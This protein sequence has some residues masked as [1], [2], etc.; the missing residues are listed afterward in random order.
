MGKQMRG[1]VYGCHSDG[2]VTSDIG[3]LERLTTTLAFYQVLLFAAAGTVLTSVPV[4][5]RLAVLF[6]SEVFS[7]QDTCSLRNSLWSQMVFREGFCCLSLWF[8]SSPGLV[9][10]LGTEWHPCEI[11]WHGTL[12][13]GIMSL[14]GSSLASP[15]ILAGLL[16]QIETTGC[17][18]IFNSCCVPFRPY[19]VIS[20]CQFYALWVFL[21]C[22]LKSGWFCQCPKYVG[23]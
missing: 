16:L 21:C 17:F 6:L 1:Q 11:T 13:R 15:S 20:F 9:D 3:P 18:S 4:D 14:L 5:D 23:L 8:V 2:L 12:R 10:F 22:V 19:I 7:V